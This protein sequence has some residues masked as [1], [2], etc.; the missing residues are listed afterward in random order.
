MQE[1]RQNATTV[2][3][4]TPS[5][6]RYLAHLHIHAFCANPIKRQGADTIQGFKGGI[7]TSVSAV[8]NIHS[9]RK[10][11]GGRLIFGTDNI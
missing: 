7:P 9:P 10:W 5:K 4:F 3:H 6:N 11:W 2:S 1:A 8:T